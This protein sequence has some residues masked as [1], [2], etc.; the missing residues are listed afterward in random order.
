MDASVDFAVIYI[1]L[2]P[3]LGAFFFVN[4]FLATVQGTKLSR[5]PPNLLTS[6]FYSQQATILLLNNETMETVKMKKKRQKQMA[7]RM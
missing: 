5:P 6:H 3:M 1:L 7:T 2:V 4:L